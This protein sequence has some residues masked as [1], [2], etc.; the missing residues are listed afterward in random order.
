MTNDLVPEVDEDLSDECYS[1]EFVEVDRRMR[2]NLPYAG[3][4]YL[5]YNPPNGR[6]SDPGLIRVTVCEDD[7]CVGP[8]WFVSLGGI[9]EY[10]LETCEIAGPVAPDSED[11]G[12]FRNLAAHLRELAAKIE[13]RVSTG[14]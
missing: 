1:L 10:E 12:L 2:E 14:S 5:D 4:P 7:S 11:A 8:L 6:V 3:L 9:I 13:A